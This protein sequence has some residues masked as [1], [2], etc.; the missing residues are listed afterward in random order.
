[1]GNIYTKGQK[2]AYET[3]PILSCELWKDLYPVDGKYFC[4][5][6]RILDVTSFLMQIVFVYQIWVYKKY[7]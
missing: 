5:S 1:M 3:V 6:D 4:A 2:T 7:Y